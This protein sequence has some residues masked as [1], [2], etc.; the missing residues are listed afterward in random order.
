MRRVLAIATTVS[1]LACAGSESGTP[2]SAAAAAPA[3]LTADMVSGT[4]SGV[5]LAEGSDSVVTRWT[6]TRDANEETARLVIDGSTDTVLFT[7]TYDADSMISTSQPYTSVVTPNTGPV[8]FR[9]VGRLVDGKLVGTT[10]IMLAS[11]PDSVVRRNR[12]EATRQP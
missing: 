5:T 10:V 8:T 12:Y 7:S 6:I 3:M 9:S 1:L 11:N 4:W 2:D